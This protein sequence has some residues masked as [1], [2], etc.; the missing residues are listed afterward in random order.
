MAGASD[1]IGLV[2][3]LALRV[4]D[5]SGDSGQ[6]QALHST[7]VNRLDPVIRR[8]E[9]TNHLDKLNMGGEGTN[10]GIVAFR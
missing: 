5:R 4:S 8:D 3:H 1:P 7:D 6:K 9:R 2:R 10:W